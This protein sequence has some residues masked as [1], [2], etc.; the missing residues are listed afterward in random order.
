M[1]SLAIDVAA[2]ASPW[3]SRSPGD[4]AL[5]SVG[6]LITAL[7]LPAWPASPLVAATAVGLAVG[8]ARVPWRVLA[9]AARGA[10][11]FIVI[12]AVTLAVTW[13]SGATGGLGLRLGLGLTVSPASAAD[14]ARTTAHAVAGTAAM[15]LLATT[16]PI[17]DLLAWARR[18]GVPEAVT[19]VAGLTYRLLFVLLGSL[20]GVRD[21]QTARLGYASRR[22][23]ARSAAALTAAVLTRAWQRAR[24]LEDGLAGRGLDGPLRVLDDARPSSSRFVVGAL[25]LP[26]VVVTVSLVVAR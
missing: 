4:K 12:G 7:V 8:P 13:R 24:R 22:A 15:L 17:S 10:L 25:V 20:H 3:R 23:A 14:A 1:R 2:W 16:T 6:L 5:L 18:R 26:V 9:R 21:A 11:T 19:D